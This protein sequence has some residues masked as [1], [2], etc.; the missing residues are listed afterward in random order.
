MSKI[1]KKPIQ[2]PKD[3]KVKIESGKLIL[4]GPKGSRE[5]SLNDK[6][7][8]ASISKDS[9]LILK[10]IKKNETSSIM[11]G[12]TRSIIN[13][14]LIGVAVGYEKI[15]EVT[16]V[17]YRAMLKGNVLNLQLGFS[18]DISYE[19]PQEVRLTVEKNTIIKINGIDKELV[20]KVA[21]EIKMFKPVEPY[22]GKGIKER[23]Q[24]VLR[25]EGKK[26]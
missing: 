21:S 7:F 24:Y 11:W 23:G 17:G 6:I 15:L 25:K 19:I 10:L 12:T 4:T 3:T 9:N 1:G 18:H 20:G 13:N 16:G 26:K 22:K 8:S 5:L 14:A 2:I